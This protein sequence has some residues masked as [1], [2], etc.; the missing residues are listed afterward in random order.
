MGTYTFDVC[1]RGDGEIRESSIG[2]EWTL[3]QCPSL[4]G[5]RFEYVFIVHCICVTS[6]VV[7][8]QLMIKNS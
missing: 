4:F 5:R 7:C 2:L 8:P 3:Y 1:V 6:Y